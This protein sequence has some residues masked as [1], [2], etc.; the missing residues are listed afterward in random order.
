VEENQKEKAKLVGCDKNS[1]TEWPREKKI[2]IILIKR[3]HSMQCSHHP[4]LSLLLSSKCSY[5]SQL[6]T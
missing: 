6:P 1:L 4:M 2:T 3:I 5:F